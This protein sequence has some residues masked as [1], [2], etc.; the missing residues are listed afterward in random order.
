MGRKILKI[1]LGI[2]AAAL[3]AALGFVVYMETRTPEYVPETTVPTTEAAATETTEVPTTV[4]ETTIPETTVPA[5]TEPEET[6]PL[7]IRY[8]LTFAGDCTLAADPGNYASPHGFIQTIG[9]DY[10]YPFRNVLD[11]FEKD[12]FTIINLESVLADSGAGANKLFTFRGPTAYTEIM[13]GSSVEAVTL[14]NNHTGDYGQAGY[15]STIQA[16]TDAEIHFVE[17][18]K[19]TL[20]TTES[21]LVIGLYADAFQFSTGEIQKNVQKL[22][23]QG[24]EI[25]ICAFHWGVEGS[26]RPTADQK[27][28]AHA[29]I[30]AGADVVYGHH[31][32]VLQP[33]EEY[34]DGFILYSLGNFSFGGNHFPR[35]MDSALIQLEVIR[36]ETGKVSL[37][38]LTWIPVSISSMQGQNNFQPTPYEAGTEEY[39]R[40]VSKLDGSFTGPDLV[41]NYDHLKPTE[42]PTEAPTAPPASEQPPAGTEAPPAPPAN[43]PDPT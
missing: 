34:G 25:V 26:Y 7:E 17:E 12:D 42:P 35:D 5:T 2:C 1:L 39:D 27:K 33:V 36:D 9:T 38:A 31:P 6:E 16:L 28:F 18:N 43:E 8:T 23:E 15:D 4:P 14:A 29:A 30:D 37:G 21:G 19:T 20:L 40:T 11:Y 22:R 13:T 32:H 24:A 3:I 41:V 10:G